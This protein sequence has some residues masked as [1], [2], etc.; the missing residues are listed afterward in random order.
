M[1]SARRDRA[2]GRALPRAAPVTADDVLE[3]HQ[4]LARFQGDVEHLIRAADGDRDRTVP[5]RSDC[6]K[7]DSPTPARPSW[8]GSSTTTASPGNTSRAPFPSSGTSTARWS[9]ASRPTSTCPSSTMYLELTTLKQSLV[10]RKNR[11]LRRLRELYPDIRVKLFYGKDFRALMLKYGRFDLAASLSGLEGQIMPESRRP[12]HGRH[13]AADE[14]IRSRPRP[15]ARRMTPPRLPCCRRSRVPRR[16]MSR[17]SRRR[18]GRR[19]YPRRAQ[20]S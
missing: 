14:P 18:R 7:P 16:R 2:P 12:A 20:R 13:R 17:G 15:H 3:M 11:K 4:F 19:A 9:R 6:R 1:S 10:R 5:S 8:R